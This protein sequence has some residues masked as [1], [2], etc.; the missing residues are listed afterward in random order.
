MNIVI[1]TTPNSELKETG[2]GTI[3]SCEHVLAS[4]KEAGHTCSLSSCRTKYELEMVVKKKPDLVVLGVKY[5]SIE[6]EKNI[7]LS[8]FF[9]SHDINFT[10][11]LRDVLQFDSDKISAKRQVNKH[12]IKTSGFLLHYQENIG[13]KAHYLFLSL[14]F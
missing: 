11:S 2:F 5:L 13:M 7:W 4:I 8:G 10:G 1:V 12:K 14:Y 6:D 3:R 9:S